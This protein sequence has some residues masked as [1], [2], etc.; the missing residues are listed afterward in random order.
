RRTAEMLVSA[1][2]PDVLFT[3][4]CDLLASQFGAHF[5]AIVENDRNQLHVRWSFVA[6]DE[7]P[8]TA[9]EAIDVDDLDLQAPTIRSIPGERVV[10]FIPLRY[11][12]G[13]FGFLTLAGGAKRFTHEQVTLLETCA[14]YMAVA[15]FNVTLAREKERLEALATR[16]ALTGAYNRRAFDERLIDEWRRAV[17]SHEPL[18]LVMV[19]V[20]YFKVYN[21]SYG[22]VA[23]DHCLQQ[24]V[25]ALMSCV[26]RSGDM[27]ARYGGEEFV[28]LLPSTPEQGAI[29]VAERMCH[30]VAELRIMHRGSELDHVSI[31]AGVATM[32]ASAEDI[33][34]TLVTTSDA[35]L[36]RAKEG[37]RNRAAAGTYLGNEPPARRR[38]EG[39]SNLPAHPTSFIG[40]E[41][42]LAMI[43]RALPM[44]AV[45]SILGPGGVGKTRI[46]IAAAQAALP[47]FPGG[48][49]LIE[50][51]AE[52]DAERLPGIVAHAMGLQGARPLEV[53]LTS[54][55]ASPALIILDSC[56]H[57]LGA[58]KSLVAN[59]TR[60]CPD[61]RIVT[62]SRQPLEIS[63]EVGIRLEPFPLADATKLF[64]ARAR[65][66]RPQFAPGSSD[67]LVVREVVGRVDCLPLGIE[68]AAMRLRN[69]SLQQ[70][71][72]HGSPLAHP[73]DLHE[74]I[75]WS[76]DM[77][78]ESERRFLAR[79]SIFRGPFDEEAARAV[80]GGETFD[81]PASFEILT[82]L[83]EK[84]LVQVDLESGRYRLLATIAD[85]VRVRLSEF[86]EP[87]SVRGAAMR[88][89]AG[90]VAALRS[91]LQSGA[92]PEIFN[93]YAA[94]RENVEAVLEG[95][96]AGEDVESGAAL[97][98][99]M[100][101]YWIETGRFADASRFLGIAIGHAGRLSRRR[102]LDVLESA[103]EIA[104]AGADADRLE[105]LAGRLSAETGTSNDGAETARAMLALALAHHARARFDEA[106]SLYHHASNAFR[107]AGD[108]RS[109]ARALLGW[110]RIVADEQGDILRAV[111]LLTEA[112]DAA[113]ASGCAS[114]LLDIVAELVEVNLLRNDEM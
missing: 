74:R 13:C 77:L 41:A 71:A 100:A 25:Q 1:L 48:V 65:D 38:F 107:I 19:D 2:P 81:G 66:V 69:M 35:A 80:A 17:R 8:S 36:Y 84:S 56:E 34:Q 39:R 54:L 50:V 14:R 46:A 24:V 58:S 40:R 78:S 89:Y 96:L 113:R 44:S 3:R 68:L 87:G 95:A 20:D 90:V 73:T 92:P 91:E 67:D 79:L 88:H 47:T 114:I 4:V 49:W 33:A 86:D 6:G 30:K 72:E 105:H 43:S 111:A 82:Q 85:Y 93:R 23:G 45:V 16:D 18:S 70:L 21:D 51:G 97:A 104:A 57:L 31:S 83:V 108:S 110:S 11:G 106:G 62:T 75:G 99:G 10:L 5:V 64:V 37:G 15:I 42:E 94:V 109:L 53:V 98:A 7:E 59:I 12:E 26:S 112:L 52:N 28:A 55:A 63:G 60:H 9:I 22:H 101:D 76:F 61:A 27:V 32:L 29:D 103:I 102:M